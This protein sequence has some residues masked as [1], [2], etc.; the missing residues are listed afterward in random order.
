MRFGDDAPPAVGARQG[1][2]KNF[3]LSFGVFGA[4][5]KGEPHCDA[6]LAQAAAADRLVVLSDV[7]Q[8]GY[9]IEG[10]SPEDGL[11]APRAG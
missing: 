2:M 11:P 10:T 5:A 6:G 1:L 4:M 3:S 8:T 7:P 9:W